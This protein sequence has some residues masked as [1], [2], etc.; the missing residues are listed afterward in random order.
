MEYDLTRVSKQN[1]VKLSDSTS[2]GIWREN[3]SLKP[4]WN[5]PLI[6]SK[7]ILII[8]LVIMLLKN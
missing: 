4:C 5:K 1:L 2:G 3:F 6:T 8:L 7:F